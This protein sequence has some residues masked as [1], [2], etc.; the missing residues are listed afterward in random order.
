MENYEAEIQD[1]VVRINRVAKTVKGGRNIRFQ[2]V[3]VVGDGHGRVGMGTGKALEVP[4]AIR[5]AK[6]EAVKNM[7]DVT[8]DGT[9]IPHRIVGEYG[10]G[11]VLLM[12]ATPGTGVISGGSVRA[13]MELAGIRD[14]RSK[15]LGSSNP[16]N[17]VAATMEALKALRSVEDVAKVRGKSPEE[18]L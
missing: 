10:A 1:R 16:L 2:A 12:P 5:K 6:D 18:I 11:K 3:V 7:I 15:S 13:V 17:V 14:V 8:M 9:S 4:A